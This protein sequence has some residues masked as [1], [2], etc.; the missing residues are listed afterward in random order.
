MKNTI[1]IMLLL[2]M[3]LY[4]V[5][6]IVGQDRLH[7]RA[8]VAMVVA[9]SVVA[10]VVAS[11]CFSSRSRSTV[12]GL[13]GSP[14]VIGLGLLIFAAIENDR[15]TLA[16]LPLIQAWAIGLTAPVWIVLSVAL[17]AMKK[18]ER[19]SDKNLDRYR[20]NP[21]PKARLRANRQGERSAETGR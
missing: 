12:A 10:P 3:V 9:L 5:W 13:V 7:P 14:V 4:V 8:F 6:M 21:R 1:R 18:T 16:W 19:E 2:V 11:R 15:E 17:C 20:P